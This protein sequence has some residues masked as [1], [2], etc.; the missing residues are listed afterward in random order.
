MKKNAF[1]HNAS[2]H[3]LM[4]PRYRIM[5]A[6]ITKME[7][8]AAKSFL[9][10]ATAFG[11]SKTAGRH[12][13]QRGRGAYG[14]TSGIYL[15]SRRFIAADACASRRTRTAARTQTGY[16]PF[17]IACAARLPH[18]ACV[19]KTW[20]HHICICLCRGVVRVWC[21]IIH[22]AKCF[23]RRRASGAWTPSWRG[24]T[25]WMDGDGAG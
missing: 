10:A 25:L 5:L 15:A 4:L 22:G 9:R 23:S 6:V 17:N 16:L 2:A 20:Y 18:R 8:S 1:T 3:A 14:K 19:K 7:Q 13:H 12:K 24:V 11:C 21:G